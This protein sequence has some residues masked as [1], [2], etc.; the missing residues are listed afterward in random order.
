MTTNP[1]GPTPRNAAFIELV[2][3]ATL[4]GIVEHDLANHGTFY[5]DRWYMMLGYDAEHRPEASA[6]LW[7]ELSHPDDLPEV[8]EDWQAHVEEAWPFQ[9][10]W[11]MRHYHGGYRWVECRSVA[12]R[13]E[14]GTPVFALSLF[15][16]ITDR[17]QQG[18]RHQALLEAIPDVLLRVDRD[19][20]PL[21]CAPGALPDGVKIAEAIQGDGQSRV[22]IIGQLGQLAQSSLAQ[23]AAVDGDFAVEL[24]ETTRRVEARV[25]PLGD[26]EAICLLRDVTERVQMEEQLLQ[27][28]KLESIGRLAAGVAHEINTPLQFIGDNARF[29]SAAFGRLAKVIDGLKKHADETASEE[30]RKQL[31]KLQRRSKLDYVLQEFPRALEACVAG[32]DRV[33]V[34]VAA[35][36][37]FSHPGSDH[38]V[39]ADLNRALQSTVQVSVN[40]WKTVANVELELA[41]S[42]PTVVCFAGELNQCFL[43]IIVNAA[44]AIEEAQLPEKGTI[45]ISS[46]ALDSGVEVCIKDTG[47]GIPAHI[48]QRIFDPFFTTKAVG[49]GTGQGLAMARSTIV[50]R[51]HGQLLCESEPGRGTAFVIRLPYDAPAEAGDRS[52]A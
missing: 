23:Q 44:H 47:P 33:A 31:A 34:I 46:R 38:P 39:A 8:L 35:M 24:A 11:R 49:K 18:L 5:H 36:K 3:S 7:Q 30:Q 37:E 29:C 19:G 1:P 41:E 17:I 52:V 42:L 16:D 12:R 15:S 25:C 22:Q 14:N 20:N 13:D 48:Q 4:E 40:E 50:D 21:D 26:S 43:N 10:H 28:R 51:H 27:A 9:R 32:V 45:T 6:N 2:M